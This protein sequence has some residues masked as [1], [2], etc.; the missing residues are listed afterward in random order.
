M[1]VKERILVIV[2]DFLA[3]SDK[4]E[5]TAKDALYTSGLL[6]SIEMFELLINIENAGIRLKPLLTNSSMKLPLENVDSVE[7]M[8]ERCYTD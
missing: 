1:S 2:N 8:T 3:E 4:G 5:V 7:K 6:E